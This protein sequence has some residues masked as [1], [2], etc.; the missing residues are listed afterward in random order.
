MTL[1]AQPIPNTPLNPAQFDWT[2]HYGRPEKGTLRTIRPSRGEKKLWRKR[3]K[4][5]PSEWAERYRVLPN[6]AS[7]PGRWSNARVPYLAGIMD[8]AM[9]QCVE[10]VTLCFSPQAGKTEFALNML[11]YLADY[12]PGPTAYLM[13]D[14]LTAKENTKD[15]IEP[16]F[17]ESR[18]LSQ[19]LTGLEADKSGIRLNLL[20]MSIYMLW[21]GSAARLA[22]KPIRYIFEDE[23]DKYPERAGK[24]ESSPDKLIEKRATTFRGRRKIFKLSTPTS[25]T[26]VIWQALQ[27]SQARFEHLVRCP[28]CKKRQLMT[29]ENIR[30]PAEERN[31]VE[32]KARHLARYQ[33]EHC[34]AQWDDDERD[35]AV[36]NGNWYLVEEKEKKERMSLKRAMV[37]LKPMSIGFQLPSWNSPFVSLSEI[38]AD[39]LEAVAEKRLTGSRLKLH[40]FYNARRAEPYIMHAG[41]DTIDRILKLKDDRPSGIVPSGGIVAG[42]VAGIDTQDV[43][44]WYEIRAFSYG[45]EQKSWGIRRGYVLEFED[46]EQVLFESEYAGLD[47]KKYHVQMAVM[48]S[49]GHRTAEVYNFCV[50]HRHRIIPFKGEQRMNSPFAWSPLEYFP[51]GQ[52]QIPGGLRLLRAN[53]THYK[54]YLSNKLEVNPADPGAWLYDSELTEEWAKMMISEYRDDK[55]LWQV[56]L[57]RANHGWDCSVYALVAAD[58]LGLR[59]LKRPG[60]QP[61]PQQAR[62][63]QQRPAQ[64]RNETGAGPSR[65]GWMNGRW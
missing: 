54:D 30:W 26:G 7:P 5:K 56:K 34:D 17:T 21:A 64:T 15:R 46:L 39:W 40:D 61:Q 31:P 9:A 36:R 57:S 11:G 8:A 47:G 50:Q 24:N 35:V 37:K 55:G 53:V 58:V 3:A 25:E 52:K 14:E 28:K 13:P 48:D 59:M 20:Q 38:A 65:P 16:L 45:Q 2:V 33:C 62:P 32:I 19:Y 22:S 18:H 12:A 44:F 51:G 10:T 49:Q 41:S 42:L 63:A 27:T 4:I 6:T 23:T 1:S 43:G 29:F 60:N